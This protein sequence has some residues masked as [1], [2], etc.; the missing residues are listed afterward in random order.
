VLTTTVLYCAAGDFD[1]VLLIVGEPLALAVVG[2]VVLGPC[3]ATVV[4]GGRA[5]DGLPM[6]GTVTN[7]A[8]VGPAPV[9]DAERDVP[10][11]VPETVSAAFLL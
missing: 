8:V 4:A 6:S 1:G 9:A 3:A 11:A 2:P 7:V 5:V 10:P